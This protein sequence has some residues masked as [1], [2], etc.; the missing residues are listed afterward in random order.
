MSASRELQR[1]LK[2]LEL[3]LPRP[4]KTP[5]IGRG[6]IHEIKHDGFRIQA[7]RDSQGVT[8]HTRRGY[9]FADRFP[10][11]VAAVANLPVNSCLIDGEAI[12]SDA[13]GLAV[14]DLLRGKPAFACLGGG[15][16]HLC[17]GGL[18]LADE[19]AVSSHPIRSDQRFRLHKR[20]ASGANER[21]KP[22]LQGVFQFSIG[23]RLRP[24]VFRIIR[25]AQLDGD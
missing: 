11:A 13:N 22:V 24:E 18:L 5:P 23:P 21:V 8:L 10:L 25:S 17:G 1:Q 4:A 19:P 7:E 15:Q 16:T 3:C 2:R 9:D 6:W 12:V 14:F 20:H